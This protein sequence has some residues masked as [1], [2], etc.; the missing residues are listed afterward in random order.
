MGNIR[1]GTP[2]KAIKK[3][4]I[5]LVV[6]WYC[7]I[8]KHASVY[9]DNID[10][11]EVV[12]SNVKIGH[13]TYGVTSR[14]IVMADSPNPP[15]VTIGCFCS[16]APG[17]SL[18]ANADHPMDIPSTYPFKTLLFNKYVLKNGGTDNNLDVISK[19]GIH[20]GNDVWIGLNAIVLSGVSIGTGAVIG[21]GSVVTKNIP[22]YAIAV[23]NP[24]KVI[25]FRFSTEIIEQLLNSEWWLLPDEKLLELE[26]YFYQEDI[27]LFLGKVR[28]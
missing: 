27:N 14:S 4:L 8:D 13:G 15:S 17:V 24:A 5:K 26:T 11:H 6:R 21:A 7:L 28:Q 18:L 22:P 3:W 9:R 23:G 16:F 1:L 10:S 19:G 2:L 20:I 12:W 25:R